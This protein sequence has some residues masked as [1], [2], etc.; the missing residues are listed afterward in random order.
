MLA[1]RTAGDR[2]PGSRLP[3]RI[4]AGL[5]LLVL[6]ALIAR[7]VV[8]DTVRGFDLLYYVLPLVITGALLL[9]AGLLWLRTGSRGLGFACLACGALLIGTWIALDHVRNPCETG[10]DDLRLVL[11]NVA[12]GDGGWEAIADELAG[13]PAD[14]IGLVEAYL[15]RE[16]GPEFWRE[17]FPEHRL[18]RLRGGLVLLVRGEVLDIRMLVFGNRSRWGVAD[19]RVRGRPLRVVL[20]DLEADPLSPRGPLL[21][22]IVSVAKEGRTWP[23]V[24][25]GDFNTPI[26]ATRLDE[27][28]ESFDEAFEAAGTGL[29]GTWPR[30][31]PLF[32]LDQIW[33]AQEISVACATKRFSK[34]SDHALLNV[35]LGEWGAGGP[36]ED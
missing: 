9:P 28:R 27:L 18:V 14:L 26:D 13:E 25:M 4:A 31:L 19:L 6:V 15:D 17:R 12:R 24:V 23:Q 2:L 33:V 1:G 36:D 35:R 34:L 11:W 30:Y 10:D 16:Q 20:V 5:T 3:R 8:A 29:R 22:E 32:K 7:G 21:E